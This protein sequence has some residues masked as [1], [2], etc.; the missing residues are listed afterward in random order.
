MPL[1]L[2]RSRFRSHDRFCVH[3]SRAYRLT[4][5]VADRFSTGLQT[6]NLTYDAL[7]HR[8]ESVVGS[9]TTDYLYDPLGNVVTDV[10][11]TCGNPCW[12]VSYMYMN[13]LLTAE[14]K[15]ST[16]YFVHPDHLGSTRLLTG[17]SGSVI[18][19]LDYLPFG[20]L[21]S[22][23]PG[24][25]SHEFTGDQRDAE[26]TASD[27][28]HA[29][30]RQYSPPMA[31]WMT[32]DPAGLAAVDPSNPQ[33]WSRYPYVLNNPVVL[34]DPTGLISPCYPAITCVIL[35][36]IPL[37][38]GG[39]GG[40]GGI[41]NGFPWPCIGLLS[42]GPAG[43]G[44]PQAPQPPN[45]DGKDKKPSLS[46]AAQ[47]CVAQAQAQI[48]QELQTFGAYAGVRL[49]GRIVIGAGLG[50]LSVARWTRYGGPWGLAAGAAIGGTVGAVSTAYSDSNTIKK[51]QNSFMD[52]FQAC[53]Q[54]SATPLPPTQ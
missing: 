33:S 46:P 29:Q 8:V 52:K 39:V 54:K 11:N 30:F 47:A 10:N 2:C 42:T 45:N 24:Y 14:Y 5:A 23:D 53:M 41:G 28:H 20:E 1:G 32:P 50:A 16:T 36:N 43:A 18:Q 31:R 12:A 27:L 4:N 35:L 38:N 37:P 26:T 17:M 49:F 48:Q 25:T 3:A 40:G 9:T 22:S 6:F 19:V 13:G 34:T 7:G 21:N 44:C 51:I 15:N